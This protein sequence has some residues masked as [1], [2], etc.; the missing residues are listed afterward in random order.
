MRYIPEL[1]SSR[2]VLQVP[3]NQNSYINVLNA[4]ATGRGDLEFTGRI[5]SAT[6]SSITISDITDGNLG[7]LFQYLDI[8]NSPVDL[9]VFVYNEAVSTQT[10]ILSVSSHTAQGVDFSSSSGVNSNLAQLKY[11][12]FGFNPQS[13]SL[14]V[15]VSEVTVGTKVLNPDLWGTEQYVQLNF[16]RTSQ[17]VLPVIYRVWGSRVDFLGVIGNNKVGY[18]ISPCNFRDLG[19]SEVPN[20]DTEQQLPSFLSDVFL[21]DGIDVAQLKSV[22]GVSDVTVVPNP[23]DFRP[24]FLTVSGVDLPAYSAGS[25]VKFYIDDTKYIREAVN[26]AATGNI[27]EV[28]FPSGTYNLRDSSFVNTSQLD[29]SGITLRGTGEGAVLKR[30][31]VSA[32]NAG[33]PGLLNFTGQS[34]SPRLLGLKVRS[35]QINGNRSGCFST[36]SPAETETTLSVNYA[37]NIVI[38]DCTIQDSASR[39]VNISGSKSVALTGNKVINTGRPYEQSAS[40]LVVNGSEGLVVQGNIFQFATLGPKVVSTDFSTINGNII[41]GCGDSGLELETSYQWNA[42]GN[43]AYSDNDSII[44]SID[45]YNNEYSRATIEVRKGFALDPVYMTVTYGGESVSILKGETKAEIYSLNPSGVKESKIGAFRVLETSDQL[46]AGI[47]S[48]TLPAINNETYGGETIPATSTLNDP[49]GYMY[50]V[51]STVLIGNGTRGYRPST[52][53]SIDILG[54]EYAAI[55]LANSSDLLSLQIY[56]NGSIEN[57]KIL[58]KDF[59]NIEALP[60]WDMGVGYQVIDIDTN[61]N[62]IIIEMPPGLTLTTTPIT[63]AGGNLYILRSNYFIADGNLFVHSF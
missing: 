8:F 23:T 57:D 7:T 5:V 14:P 45:T 1:Q 21:V 61:S 38:N 33:N 2:V 41:R 26:L 19:L 48:L 39:A 30:L 13:G 54:T 53:R 28:F 58:I 16:T 36:Q 9:R 46:Q 51:K 10:S 43:V 4:G 31:P 17:Y 60:E 59:D 12:V 50:E 52:I 55:E 49:D 27:K 11:Y 34:V 37:D 25:T 22:D 56:S 20:W 29:F 18:S 62:S 3:D 42:Q 35:M 40:P 15:Y 44:R 6:S 63:F 47:F 24:S 32:P